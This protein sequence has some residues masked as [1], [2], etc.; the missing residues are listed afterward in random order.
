[1]KI[2]LANFKKCQFTLVPHPK[3]THTWCILRLPFS[4][5]VLKRSCA[6]P[7]RWS[8][9]PPFSSHCSAS[10]PSC[11]GLS[12]CRSK[13]QRATSAHPLFSPTSGTGSAQW[14]Q[15]ECPCC[16][17]DFCHEVTAWEYHS[18]CALQTT[19]VFGKKNNILTWFCF[20]SHFLL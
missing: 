14:S 19:N 3:A 9:L 11:S 8:I 13:H 16:Q 1:M 2:M 6:G 17:R 15:P 20:N 12:W 18:F 10:R 5:R 4:V 7:F